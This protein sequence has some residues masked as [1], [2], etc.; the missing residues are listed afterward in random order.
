[1]TNVETFL[2]LIEATHKEKRPLSFSS[3]S[4]EL[5]WTPD[6]FLCY[7]KL[8]EE[9]RCSM[10]V[11]NNVLINKPPSYRNPILSASTDNL[12]HWLIDVLDADCD[13][14]KDVV[15]NFYFLC[16]TYISEKY[17]SE[18][19][20]FLS[21]ENHCDTLETNY[22]K[23]AKY[24]FKSQDD[25]RTKLEW[26]IRT[27]LLNNLKVEF[28]EPLDCSL[29]AAEERL[30]AVEREIDRIKLTRPEPLNQYEDPSQRE[31]WAKSVAKYLNALD[32]LDSNVHELEEY[33]IT[34]YIVE[35][36]NGPRFRA[37]E[38]ILYV[39]VGSIKCM[40]NK[41]DIEC[42]TGVIKNARGN[43]VTLNINHCKE[44]DIFFISYDEYLYYRQLYGALICKIKMV[45]Y[46]GDKQLKTVPRQE[47]SR[48]IQCGYNVNHLDDL[49][50]CERQ[51]TLLEIIQNNILEKYEVINYLNTFI[52]VNG[53]KQYMSEAVAKWSEDLEYV[54]NINIPKQDIYTLDDIRKY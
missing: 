49:T 21:P 18:Y 24:I 10:V 8:C 22:Y 25:F 33:I 11:I 32:T 17:I 16:R 19:Y 28:S 6:M 12:M 39:H 41:H 52:R 5:N 36:K 45:E 20:S 27:A 35:E 13:I 3:L 4:Q 48:L 50:S 29:S 9:V 7:L 26:G 46:S 54:R 2:S 23:T 14:P 42:V 47:E 31:N 38:N 51:Q 1:M 30:K 44:C 43:Q 15:W 34:E 40:R 37:K 53:A